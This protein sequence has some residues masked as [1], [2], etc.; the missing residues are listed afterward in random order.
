[1]ATKARIEEQL[2]DAYARSVVLTSS[3]LVVRHSVQGLSHAL[4]ERKP[5]STLYSQTVR[6]SFVI[7]VCPCLGVKHLSHGSFDPAPP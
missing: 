4:P 2:N 7:G 5:Y 1:M 6:N 3:E